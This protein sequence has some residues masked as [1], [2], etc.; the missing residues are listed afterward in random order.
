[1][2]I[3]IIYMG[4]QYYRVTVYIALTIALQVRVLKGIKY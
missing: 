4:I 2:Y 1:M 3:Y